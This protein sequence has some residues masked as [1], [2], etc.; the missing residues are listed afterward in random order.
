MKQ[1]LTQTNVN[2]FLQPLAESIQATI[3]GGSEG[4]TATCTCKKTEPKLRE[5]NPYL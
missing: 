5:K 2:Q 1:I 3:R 4:G